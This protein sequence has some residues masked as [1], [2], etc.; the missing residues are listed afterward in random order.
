MIK[1]WPVDLMLGLDEKGQLLRYFL[2]EGYGGPLLLLWSIGISLFLLVFGSPIYAVAWTVVAVTLGL[3]MT[4]SARGNPKVWERL[5]RAS[6]A[7][8][9]P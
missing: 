8:R 9:F 5:V 1:P 6:M 4:Y 7:K 2:A 3:W